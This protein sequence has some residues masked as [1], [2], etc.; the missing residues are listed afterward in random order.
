MKHLTLVLVFV[1]AS[2]SALANRKVFKQIEKSADLGNGGSEVASYNKKLDKA[3]LI[4][5]GKKELKKQYWQNCGPWKTYDTRR[6]AIKMIARL[7]ENSEEAQ[8]AKLLSKLYDNN[9]IVAIVA[10][11]SNHEVECSLYWFI[12]YGADGS[13]LELHYNMGD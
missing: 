4:E 5:Q 10:A 9:E 12:V 6:T 13:K 3:D 2:S 1:V 7:E 8:T 11:E